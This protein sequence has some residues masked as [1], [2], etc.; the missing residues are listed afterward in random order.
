MPRIRLRIPGKS[1]RKKALSE[2]GPSKMN[3]AED[4]WYIIQCLWAGAGYFSKIISKK[5]LSEID[6]T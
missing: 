4:A 6:A 5:A 2:A 3:G 1:H